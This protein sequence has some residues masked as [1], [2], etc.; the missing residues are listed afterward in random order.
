MPTFAP[1]RSKAEAVARIYSL[2]GATPEPL[3]PGSK[4]RKSVLVRLA[5]ALDLDVDLDATKPVL[6]SQIASSLGTTWDAECFSVGATITLVGLN[7]L[8]EA[9]TAE[10]ASRAHDTRQTLPLLLTG[11]DEFA[12]ARSKLEAVN[13]ISVLTDSGPQNLGPGS[14]ERKSVLAN[15]AMGMGLPVRL[16]LSKSRLGAAIAQSL[17]VPWDQSCHSTGE[18]ITLD[19][20]N[21]ILAGMERALGVLGTDRHFHS[22]AQEAAAL[23]A[24]LDNAL[25]RH[26]DGRTS[27]LEMRDA[28]FS[29]WRQSEWPGFYF[30]FMGIP[31]MVDAF[32]GG[33][34]TVGSVRFDYALE[35][36]WDLKC[37]SNDARG[38]APLNDQESMLLAL[39]SGP[40]GLLV[41]S[42][43]RE[44]DP[45]GAFDEWHREVTAT[46]RRPRPANSDRRR[47]RKAAFTPTDIGAFVVRDVRDHDALVAAGVLTTM[48]QGRQ[49]GGASRKPKFGLDLRRANTSTCLLTQRQL[50][51]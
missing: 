39:S 5:R 16:S 7:R 12:P 51:P 30:E 8:L 48:R 38:A 6:G 19:G 46:G 21:V 3:G 18:T 42:G 13:R 40:L 15:A 11:W 49:A 4:E 2:A 28:E 37:H 43:D 32:G 24:A 44:T 34:R 23:L 36:T 14:K 27:V 50:E 29:Q 9:G 31:A 41:L 20:L 25:P 33:P 26:W 47:A 10:L 1:A 17:D 35:T 45:T 22:I